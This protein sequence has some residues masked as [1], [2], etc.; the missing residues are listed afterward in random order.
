MNSMSPLFYFSLGVFFTITLDV[1]ASYIRGFYEGYRKEKDGNNDGQDQKNVV[2]D[3]CFSKS[4]TVFFDDDN[5][6]ISSYV[7]HFFDSGDPKLDNLEDG[8][9]AYIDHGEKR[10]E[11]GLYVKRSGKLIKQRLTK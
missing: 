10:N 2:F 8:G 5:S 6:I 9:Y 3:I 11:T 7:V 1:V 4:K